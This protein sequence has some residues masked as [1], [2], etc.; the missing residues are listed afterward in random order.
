[1]LADEVVDLAEE[2]LA[3][4]LA[5]DVLMAP[6]EA[7]RAAHEAT[8]LR[9][10]AEVGGDVTEQTQAV[11]LVEVLA[12]IPEGAARHLGL[13]AGLV[14]L[15]RVTERFGAPAKLMGLVDPFEL[16]VEQGQI[17]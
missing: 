6:E 2:D 8:T 17:A 9:R 7:E 3:L 15:A 12:V 4:S 11:R 16:S 10:C 5:A 1:M 14:E 13:A